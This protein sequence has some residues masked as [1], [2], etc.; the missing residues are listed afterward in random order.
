MQNL[1]GR[2]LLF[3]WVAFMCIWMVFVGVFVAGTSSHRAE[4]AAKWRM[5]KPMQIEGSR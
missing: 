2:N 5:G 4:A 3:A 1:K